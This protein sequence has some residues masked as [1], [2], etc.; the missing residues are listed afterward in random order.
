VTDTTTDTKT[1]TKTNTKTN[2]KTKTP[3]KAAA[4]PATATAKKPLRTAGKKKPAAVV[5]TS[6]SLDEKVQAFLAAGGEIQKI[7]TGV[8][9]QGLSGSSKG[10][11][12]DSAKKAT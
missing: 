5:E 11:P 12:S 2:T 4:K 3:A 8:G 6:E 9:M 10:K 1:S 7:K